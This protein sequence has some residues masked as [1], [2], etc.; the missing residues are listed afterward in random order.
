[1]DETVKMYALDVVTRKPHKIIAG[2]GGPSPPLLCACP[3]LTYEA[4]QESGT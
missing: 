2:V 3:S 1:M 4:T